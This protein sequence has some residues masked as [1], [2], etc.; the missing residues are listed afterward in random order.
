MKKLSSFDC[1]L[2]NYFLYQDNINL[3]SVGD[4]LDL[5]ILEKGNGFKDVFALLDG[6]IIGELF[7]EESD[8]LIRFV[9]FP[10]KFTIHVVV[11]K[12]LTKEDDVKSVIIDVEVMAEDNFDEVDFIKNYSDEGFFTKKTIVP[13]DNKKYFNNDPVPISSKKG[14]SLFFWI[15]LFVVILFLLIFLFSSF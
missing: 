3:L 13:A 11:K 15:M 14:N 1:S 4:Y 9:R 12:L 5:E 7:R 6:K 2:K 8:S 10:E